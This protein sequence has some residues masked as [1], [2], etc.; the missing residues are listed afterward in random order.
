MHGDVGALL[1]LEA[2]HEG[3]RRHRAGRALERRVELLVP[4][5]RIDDALQHRQ[6]GGRHR[7]ERAHDLGVPHHRRW[8]RLVEVDLQGGVMA[9]QLSHAAGPDAAQA[10][11]SE[12]EVA[13]ELV[14]AV[15]ARE[16]VLADA[17][18]H[19]HAG[20]LEHAQRRPRHAGAVE[21]EDQIG[22]G[23]LERLL[24]GANRAD[25]QPRGP[26]RVALRLAYERERAQHALLRPR[27]VFLARAGGEHRDLVAVA[28]RVHES[29]AAQL[30]AADRDR[31]IKIG[32]DEDAQGGLQPAQTVIA[33]A[34]PRPSI[35]GYS[36]VI[37][38]TY[39]GTGTSSMGL[40][41]P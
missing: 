15:D 35:R 38:P 11:L 14:V 13:R 24:G 33:S 39:P 41:G 4:G 6:R 1:G 37:V 20:E 12:V 31:W 26:Q 36:G 32:Y 34:A 8:H 27:D 28:Q 7:D 10:A 9:V 21:D 16:P 40:R 18:H 17:P 22:I 3:D 23:L 25:G 5:A 30:V 2:T 19:R 29:R